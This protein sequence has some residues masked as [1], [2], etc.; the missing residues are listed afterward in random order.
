MIQ[1]RRTIRKSP[2]FTDEGSPMIEEGLLIALAIIVFIAILTLVSNILSWVD[3]LYQEINNSGAIQI[4][5]FVLTTNITIDDYIRSWAELPDQAIFWLREIFLF[6]IYAAVFIGGIMIVWGAIEWATG[7]NDT[8][9]KRNII[10]GIILMIL[11]LAPA[12]VVY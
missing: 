8:G 4:T 3:E 9:G 1:F 6:L 2:L 12:L 7:Y 5:P 10:R 11:A